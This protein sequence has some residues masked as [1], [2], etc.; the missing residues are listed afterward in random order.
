MPSHNRLKPR[1]LHGTRVRHKDY[2]PGYI[3]TEWGVLAGCNECACLLDASQV[4][5]RVKSL[6]RVKTRSA[7]CNATLLVVG[8]DDIYDVLFKINGKLTLKSCHKRS[9]SIL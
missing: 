2:G 8:C 5:T 4:L 7:C 9:L 3:L 1:L 6:G